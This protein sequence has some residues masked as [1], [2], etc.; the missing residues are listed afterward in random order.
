MIWFFYL[1][2][3]L[4]QGAL[5][6]AHIYVRT[7]AWSIT[8]F[9]VVSAMGYFLADVFKEKNNFK[10]DALF[11]SVSLASTI[12]FYKYELN[13]FWSTIALTFFAAYPTLKFLLLL[14]KYKNTSFVKTGTLVCYSLI[15]LHGVDYAYAADK[16]ELMFPGYLLALMLVVAASCFTFAALVERVIMDNEVRELLQNISR[17][18][19]LGGMAAEISHEIRNP[20]TVLSLNNAQMLNKIK[21]GQVFDEDYY[22]NKFVV[23]DKM[24]KRM[25]DIMNSLRSHY[26]SGVV[27]NFKPTKIDEIFDET[28]FLCDFRA[29]KIGVKVVFNR[30]HTPIVVECRSVQIIQ[31]LQNLIQNAMDELI[32]VEAPLIEINVSVI[33]ERSIMITISDN[34]PGIPLEI[35]PH[36]FDSFFTTKT[37]EMGSGL[38][39]SIS[40]RFIEEHQGSLILDS[41]AATKFIMTLPLVQF[42]KS[43]TNKRIVAS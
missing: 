42:T 7:I 41:G 9:C 30:Y 24:L 17:L 4:S 31:A 6:E 40:K 34:G 11:F 12:L 18:C 36:I 21:K 28:G 26:N 15:A 32:E 19:A 27:D 33:D 1:L 38:G 37:K 29:K 14:Y 25:S 20:L 22:L 3:G 43:G 2:L 35:R 5:Q 16:P 8:C 13:L 39:L 23:A 10:R